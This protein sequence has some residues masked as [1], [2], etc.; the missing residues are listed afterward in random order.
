MEVQ[1]IKCTNPECDYS[2]DVTTT[3]PPHQNAEE[4]NCPKCGLKTLKEI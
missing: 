2:G 3:Q 4:M 1:N